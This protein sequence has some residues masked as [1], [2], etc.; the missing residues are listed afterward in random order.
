MKCN[1]DMGKQKKGKKAMQARA[2]AGHDN[3][4]SREK[5]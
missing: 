5:V 2:L 4:K 3:K 1:H